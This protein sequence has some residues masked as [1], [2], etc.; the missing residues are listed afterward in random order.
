MN[1]YVNLTPGDPVPPFTQRALKAPALSL[2]HGAGR[3]VLL[4]FGGRMAEEKAARAWA[5]LQA[6]GLSPARVQ[7]VAVTLDAAE[8]AAWA[9][10]PLPDG[11]DI[12]FDTDGAISRAYGAVPAADH[13]AG[14]VLVRQ[15]AVL[16]TPMQRVAAVYDLDRVDAAIVRLKGAAPPDTYAGF[17]IFAPVLVIPDVF[18]PDLCRTL[19]ETYQRQARDFSGYMVS[20]G[21]KTVEVLNHT[22]KTRRDCFVEDEA[23]LG[24]INARIARRV[25][26]EIAK[27]HQFKVTRIE[28]NLIGCYT[29]EDGGHFAAH[30]DNTTPATAHRRF[31]LSVN[32]NDDFE[33]GGV[34][35]PEYGPRSYKVPAGCAVV[36]SC[37]L[38]H[39]VTS[40][41][42]GTRYAYLPF[43]Y[44]TEGSR[45]RAAN[46]GSLAGGS[47]TPAEPG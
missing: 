33:G 42:R 11:F 9:A 28:R 14:L 46:I 16:I 37:A 7:I 6:A 39:A 1:E 30:R 8:R 40:V 41:T 36:F 10:T 18:E 12:L 34:S 25:A 31:A 29:A 38:L 32:L 47:F 27:V 45:I 4:L 44:D 23:L 26:S 22:F 5:Q 17:E 21:S 2:D 13:A 35:F 15:I 3:Y 20:S 24:Q 43:L 19:I